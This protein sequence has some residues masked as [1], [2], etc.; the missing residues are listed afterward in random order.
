MNQYIERQATQLIN[1][2]FTDSAYIGRV[3]IIYGPRQ[4]G[5][6]TLAKKSLESYANSAYF[7]CDLLQNQALFAYENAH[8]LERVV[9]G[10]DLIVLDEAQ[11]I[12]NIGIVLKILIDQFPE[13][14]IIA[15]GSSSFTLSNRIN[16]PLTGRKIV[17]RLY[18]LSYQELMNGRSPSDHK[19]QVEFALRFGSY[20]EVAL[21]GVDKAQQFLDEI[22]GSYLYR[23][24][25]TF[26]DLRK[27]A[28]LTRLLQLLAFQV[29]SEVS[30][31][32]LAT[33]LGVDTKSI[34]RYIDLLEEAF[35]I[36]RLNALS[37]NPRKE[38]SKKP[39]IY[40]YDLG[41]RNAIIQAFQPLGSRQDIG[42]LWENYCILERLKWQNYQQLFANRYFWR[43]YTQKEVDYVEEKN[44][45]L[46]A[47]EFK[48]SP[49]KKV[50]LAK[51]F[52][53]SYPDASFA[54]V[55]PGN[56]ELFLSGEV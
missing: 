1:N 42:A 31:H 2:Y 5:K 11:R 46:Y 44:G 15:T 37:R 24:I 40:F 34:Q 16:E 3:L 55:H 14:K 50:R 52:A 30:Y 54:V 41:V 49:K 36:F 22:T 10:L 35:V 53:D 26:Q 51:Q 20:P 23:D 29:G 21:N 6:T 47:Y 28:L 48:W 7:N 9:A 25:F 33:Q 4:I 43:S 17:I 32:E 19:E 18:P 12:E 39:K 56:I 27:P 45:R 13:K 8:N 38:I